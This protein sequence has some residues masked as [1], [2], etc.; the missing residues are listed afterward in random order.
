MGEFAEVH[1]YT[2]RAFAMT[3]NAVKELRKVGFD[4]CTVASLTSNPVPQTN[5]PQLWFMDESSLLATRPVNELLKIARQEGIALVRTVGDQRQH[6]AIEAGHPMRQFLD[7]GMPVAELK[8]IIHQQDPEL[9]EAVVQASQGEA[10]AAARAIDL[11]DE[12]Q[13]LNEIPDPKDRYSVSRRTTCMA[14]KQ[15]SR[16]SS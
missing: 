10:G 6:L 7:D 8:S 11:L 2:V 4:A 12:Q 15:D 14:T 9:R 16:H 1:G 5:K 3:S 13:R